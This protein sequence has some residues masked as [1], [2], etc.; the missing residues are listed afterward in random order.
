MQDKTTHFSILP[1]FLAETLL[2]ENP[3]TAKRMCWW[4]QDVVACG[5]GKSEANSETDA[6]KYSDLGA[7]DMLCYLNKFRP[8]LAKSENIPAAEPRRANQQIPS[9]GRVSVG[10]ISRDERNGAAT[11]SG[12]LFFGR[13]SSI[14][15]E[16][17]VQGAVV[18]DGEGSSGERCARDGSEAREE[19]CAHPSLICGSNFA[20]VDG[21]HSLELLLL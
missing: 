10:D 12:S 19:N 9:A 6:T 16:P 21:F 17:S 4:S 2:L 11:A 15:V 1:L 13:C 14:S 20:F 3:Q 8:E 5:T 7:G 18:S